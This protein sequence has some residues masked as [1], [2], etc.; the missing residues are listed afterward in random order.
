M[1][2]LS[3]VW[4]QAAKLLAH[5]IGEGRI[6][7]NPFHQNMHVRLTYGGR[8]QSP[9]AW[10]SMAKTAQH[11]AL[12]VANDDG[13]TIGRPLDGLRG[14]KG[15]ARKRDAQIALAIQASTGEVRFAGTDRVAPFEEEQFGLIAA[16]Q[17]TVPQ[18]PL[19]PCQLLPTLCGAPACKVCEPAQALTHAMDCC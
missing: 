12:N 18:D 10:Q 8:L 14:G 19:R 11:V 7:L 6:V 13:R 1:H 3:Q 9:W 2:P 16:A 4:M 15:A 5:Q 17:Q